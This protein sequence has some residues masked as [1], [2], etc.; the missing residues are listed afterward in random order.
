MLCPPTRVAFSHGPR[1]ESENA[2]KRPRSVPPDLIRR[3][4]ESN[5]QEHCGLCDRTCV[6]QL[7]ALMERV[8]RVNLWESHAQGLTRGR[9]MFQPIRSS[10]L[11][12][13]RH[14]P[15]RPGRPPSQRQR[16]RSCTRPRQP[17]AGLP[18]ATS[19]LRPEGLRLPRPRLVS[20]SRQ[21]ATATASRRRPCTG[22]ASRMQRGWP[23]RSKSPAL[24][25]V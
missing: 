13:H 6:L 5:L 12:R 19:A 25:S 10:S 3:G 20:A 7:H 24:G 9:H 16:V 8:R 1:S 11:T 18:L 17:Q 14:Q 21:P 2:A 22:Q 23:S 15:A 4:Q